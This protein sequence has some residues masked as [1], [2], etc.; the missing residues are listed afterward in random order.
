MRHPVKTKLLIA[1]LAAFL[2]VPAS[3]ILFGREG[4]TPP[5]MTDDGSKVSR[6]AC[7]NAVSGG[8]TLDWGLT[9][10]VEDVTPVSC[11]LR[12]TQSGG[13]AGELTT[14]EWF[15]ID[16]P[17]NKLWAPLTTLRED[18]SWNAIAHIVPP[19]GEITLDEQWESLYGALPAGRYRLVKDVLDVT[20]PGT[21]DKMYY[22]AYF[23]IE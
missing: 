21:F 15:R 12:L 23:E 5:P 3:Y 16:V 14:G 20:A 10:A 17:Q 22:Y 18:V 1:A 6:P 13:I 11:T 19:D 8:G 2:L 4:K 9:A 7:E